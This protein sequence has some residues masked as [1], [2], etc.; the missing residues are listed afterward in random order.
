MKFVRQAAQ[1]S[2]TLIHEQLDAIFG[3][4]SLPA[5]TTNAQTALYFIALCSLAGHEC[6][7]SLLLAL[8]K[9]QLK[10][11]K[12]YPVVFSDAKSV[13]GL[14]DASS[15]EHF[16]G[17][18]DFLYLQLDQAQVIEWFSECKAKL[19]FRQLDDSCFEYSFHP[20]LASYLEKAEAS[21]LAN[22][23][24]RLLY[25]N[26]SVLVFLLLHLCQQQSVVSGFFRRNLDVLLKS[27]DQII[28]LLFKKCN[29]AERFLFALKPLIPVDEALIASSL[30]KSSNLALYTVGQILSDSVAFSSE[31][32]AKSLKNEALLIEVLKADTQ[33]AKDILQKLTWPS[34]YLRFCIDAQTNHL[35]KVQRFPNLAD[36]SLNIYVRYGVL[37]ALGLK[38]LSA[39]QLKV[40]CQELIYHFD[41]LYQGTQVIVKKHLCTFSPDVA[42]A[43]VE[44]LDDGKADWIRCFDLPCSSANHLRLSLISG[45]PLCLDLEPSAL[46]S[47]LKGLPLSLVRNFPKCAILPRK[48]K[49]EAFLA[50]SILA[51]VDSLIAGSVAGAEA[52]SSKKDKPRATSSAS[53]SKTKTDL[54]SQLELIFSAFP[55]VI[56]ESALF[57]PAI[58]K[59]LSN[60]HL[61]SSLLFEVAKNSVKR[62]YGAHLLSSFEQSLAGWDCSLSA[63]PL[64][65]SRV[66]SNSYDDDVRKLTSLL[67]SCSEELDSEMLFPLMRAA[68]ERSHADFPLPLMH[69]ATRLIRVPTHFSVQD[70]LNRYIL[71]D[72]PTKRL[73]SACMLR[74]FPPTKENLVRMAVLAEAGDEASA[75]A[76]SLSSLASVEDL[77]SLYNDENLADSICRALNASIAKAWGTLDDFKCIDEFKAAYT[78]CLSRRVPKIVRGAGQDADLTQ[79]RRCSLV[80]CL[81]LRKF[82]D[83]GIEA[84][85]QWSFRELFLDPSE[86]VR[87]S[88]F[89]VAASF[90]DF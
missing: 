76:A 72:S 62:G 81:A 22:A 66:I 83:R 17:L 68:F 77:L 15:V 19:P 73:A 10:M 11:A 25:R 4:G 49:L 12:K 61:F 23:L 88:V 67:Q 29:I 63:I 9:Q 32:V 14:F 3:A 8:D 74:K 57:I 2:S 13:F 31:L 70:W 39:D 16:L 58:W 24:D 84:F 28:A 50:E 27:E 18:L 43:V 78:E 53:P 59:M 64:L 87:D 56:A 45:F 1:P 90:I 36:F 71:D 48:S 40:L 54:L 85:L 35:D 52:P 65:I 42:R 38:Q 37:P 30:A 5:R 41:H 26:A 75:I 51:T 7:L 20:N 69:E 21:R 34:G 80:H 82:A 46:L 89:N 6:P 44:N 86:P 33:K 47:F 60:R 79:R 55:E